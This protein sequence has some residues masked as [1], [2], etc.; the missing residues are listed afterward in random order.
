MCEATAYIVRQG[1]EEEWVKDVDILES[2]GD[3]LHITSL[4]G[5]HKVLKGKIKSI[6]LVEHKIILEPLE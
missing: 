1:R 4:Y 5:E 2:R 6:S 3:E